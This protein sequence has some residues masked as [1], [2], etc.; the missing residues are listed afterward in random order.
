MVCP[1]RFRA[2]RAL[3][4]SGSTRKTPHCGVLLAQNDTLDLAF[5]QGTLPTTKKAKSTPG[6]AFLR[7]G[8]LCLR[9]TR[10]AETDARLGAPEQEGERVLRVRGDRLRVSKRKDRGAVFSCRDTPPSKEK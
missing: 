2:V 6:G 10:G 4:W 3:L 8:N 5:S 7:S 9:G 1:A